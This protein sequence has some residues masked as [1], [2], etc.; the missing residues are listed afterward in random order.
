MNKIGKFFTLLVGQPTILLLLLIDRIAVLLSD[1]MLIKLKFRL[2]HGY[3]LDLEN[4]KTF[5]EKLQWLK[6]HNRKSIYTD[7]VDKISAKQ[8]VSN[9]VGADCIIPTI[10]IYESV[11]DIDWDALPNQFVIKCTH[12]SGGIVVC[13]D[14]SKL[15]VLKSKK[16]LEWGLCRRYYYQNREWPYKNVKPRLICEEYMED[17][18]GYELKDYK[19]LCFDGEVKALFVASDRGSEHEETKFDFY[20]ADFNHLPIINGHQNSSRLLQKPAS[21]ERMKEIAS[22]LSKGHSHLRVDMYDINGHA[23]FGEM[24]FYHWSG[25]VPFEPKEWDVVFGDYIDLTKVCKVEK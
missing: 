13:K 3:W 7:M 9:V 21:F 24:T 14:K 5:N 6:L 19:F 16:K 22:M 11:D 4:P 20:D 12:D 25:F 15:D 10:A 2:C 23:Y 1:E 17:E 8:Y 18:S